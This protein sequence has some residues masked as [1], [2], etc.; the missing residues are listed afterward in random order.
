MDLQTKQIG[1]SFYIYNIEPGNQ[2]LLKIPENIENVFIKGY[3]ID[4][5]KVPEGIKYI[6]LIHLGL[7]TLILPENILSVNCSNNFLQTIEIPQSL[8]YL[9]I[10]KNILSEISFRSQIDNQ[11]EHLDI[12]SNQ[13]T[14]L[15][16]Y[17]TNKHINFNENMNKIISI[18]PRIKN[19]LHMQYIPVPSS[20][21]SSDDEYSELNVKKI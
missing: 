12:R 19:W 18:A 21:E 10:N 6:E 3:Y 8:L 5:F 14:N 20:P 11:L 15:D 9:K 13:F 7:L 1:N 2:H 16:F 4:H 17:K